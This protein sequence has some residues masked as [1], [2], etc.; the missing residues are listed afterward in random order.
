MKLSTEAADLG[1]FEVLPTENREEAHGDY[2]VC[3][4][5]NVKR[6]L[7]NFAVVEYSPATLSETKLR[8]HCRVILDEDLMD[9]QV[10][11]DQSIRNAIGIPE[12]E[13]REKIVKVKLYPLKLSWIDKICYIF[14]KL[15]GWRYLV[16]RVCK[17][18]IPDIEKNVCRIPVEAFDILGCNPGDTIICEAP[19]KEKEAY[20]KLKKIKLKAYTAT[21]EMIED[22][23]KRE[24]SKLNTRYHSAKGILK[25]SPDIPRIFMDKHARTALGLIS[26]THEGKLLDGELH[27]VKVRR[28]ILNLVSKEFVS[29]GIMIL[30]TFLSATAS[31]VF[32]LLNEYLDGFLVYIAIF[33]LSVFLPLLFVVVKI[34]SMA[35]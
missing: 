30:L 16:L 35:K 28:E 19:V 12:E 29:F 34:R 8:I 23:E 32:E 17:S 20:F 1:E 27:P 9:N 31:P 33:M 26:D 10:K 11:V 7:G 13:R 4:N 5:G 15:F 25:V 21:K 24:E 2:I 22:R 6:K 18:D 14:S 3:V